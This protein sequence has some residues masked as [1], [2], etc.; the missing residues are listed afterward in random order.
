MRKSINFENGQRR[1]DVGARRGCA[2]AI[3]L[4]G[5]C[6]PAIA[7]AELP[8]VRERHGTP[9]SLASAWSY[10]GTS[11]LNT[12]STSAWSVRPTE[13][14]ALAR[15]LGANRLS[16]AAYA[17]AVQKYIQSNIAVEFRFGLGKG[18][19]GA[20]VDQSGTPFDQAQLMVEL[21]RE[22]GVVASYN[23]GSATLTAAQFG[24][25]TG[26][27]VPTSVSSTNQITAFTVLAK[28]A[29]ELAADG[30]IPSDL[31]TGAGCSTVT[32]NLS[33]ITIGH[34]WVTANGQSYDPS[35]K[36]HDLWQMDSGFVSAACG[37]SL[38]CS[39]SAISAVQTGA[40][41]TSTYVQSPNV[42]SLATAMRTQAI[43]AEARAKSQS[44]GAQLHLTREQVLG[45][46]RISQVQA[47]G[48]SLPYSTTT[49]YVF[50]GNVPDQFRTSAMITVPGSF[51]KL[52]YLDETAGRRLA[53]FDGMSLILENQTLATGSTA[54]LPAGTNVGITLNHPYA[55]AELSSGLGAGTYQDESESLATRFGQS[56]TNPG[57]YQI[58]LQAGEAS[59]SSVA[60]MTDLIKSPPRIGSISATSGMT[61][62]IAQCN[63]PSFDPLSKIAADWTSQY[64]QTLHLVEGVN[65]VRI[66]NHHAI[67]FVAN[68]GRKD[69]SG[70]ELTRTISGNFVGALSI[71]SASFDKTAEQGAAGAAAALF[72][73]IEGSSIEQNV[74][75]WSSGTASD[76]FRLKAQ[77]NTRFY[78]AAT[79]TQWNSIQGSLVGYSAAL[80]NLAAQFVAD[81]YTI[82]IPREATLLGTLYGL[83]VNDPRS[84]FVAWKPSMTRFSA[85][86]YYLGKGAG[87][88]EN[89][90]PVK[91]VKESIKA[92]TSKRVTQFTPDI[93]T[94]TGR[95]NISFPPDLAAGYG[96][97]PYGLTLNRTYSNDA[98]GPKPCVNT[99]GGIVTTSS[100]F[101]EP[102]YNDFLN[103]PGWKTSWDWDAQI[104]SDAD[105]ALGSTSGTDAAA[106]AAGV[107]TLS[108]LARLAT[109][110]IS[111]QIAL[112]VGG[113]LIADQLELNAVRVSR[114]ASSM[115]F[116][117]AADGTS[118]LPE[119]W[120]S[121]KLVKTGPDPVKTGFLFSFIYDFANIQFQLTDADGGVSSY[122]QYGGHYETFGDGN[123]GQSYL[124]IGP[125]V[126]SNRFKAVQW[127][128]TGSPRIQLDRTADVPP[129][130]VLTG[131]TTWLAGGAIT[132]VTNSLGRFIG[133]P[134]GGLT[135]SMQAEAN[136]NG[137]G[138]F[139]QTDDGRWIKYV[140]VTLAVSAPMGGCGAAVFHLGSCQLITDSL[141]SATRQGDG[142]T[143]FT[144]KLYQPDL[145]QMF[146]LET[147]KTQSNT[148]ANPDLRISYSAINRAEWSEDA[149]VQRTS[150][151]P[152]AL[153]GE[154]TKMGEV[155][156]PLGNLTRFTANEFGKTTSTTDPLLRITS[157]DYDRGGNLIAA[158]DA[159][160]GRVAYKYDLRGNRIEERKIAKPGSGLADLVKQTV[161]M[162]APTVTSCVSQITCNKV[163][164][165]IDPKGNRT[166]YAW[167]SATG[168][169]LSITSGFNA[170]GTCALAS[171]VCP[172]TTFTYSDVTGVD[173]V[174][175]KLLTSTTEKIDVTQTV[176]TSYEY[177]AAN[178]F[179]LKS[180]IVDPTGL[181]LR[182]CYKFDAAGNL[183]SQTEP[184][185][186]L[187]VCP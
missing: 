35:Y 31:G 48:G 26:L 175:F 161:Y 22:G 106:R 131:D 16:A 56:G 150:R 8:A 101:V 69:A 53:S 50:S 76:L 10:Y 177:D 23:V 120:H 92:P 27:V 21:L 110:T 59:P 72:V 123:D 79:T 90:D 169:I 135:P 154:V 98:T 124:L 103:E 126:Y 39:T 93:N 43:A 95:V 4:A 24:S 134:V 55:N 167:D 165:E 158:T 130:N 96:D 33:T 143:D 170:S 136:A 66:Q 30:G 142:K 112:V 34:V 144:Y 137:P 36:A 168:L 57:W 18:A 67:G 47:S 152:A 183:M 75:S 139:V 125:A 73:S 111:S 71:N 166:N 132:K 86:D 121:E 52:V 41:V 122:N 54:T 157:S 138:S 83:Q 1:R 117:K 180:S 64:A 38:D 70:A 88:D 63:A 133:Y 32:G 82:I 114:D 42:N 51:T 6:L 159:E 74:V 19:L 145:S 81:G 77:D 97:F 127:V 28:T 14:K 187:G 181:A 162:E 184:K 7:R 99:N 140:S 60:F 25:W 58:I 113:E 85:I 45:G 84:G 107:L 118:Y 185:A 49:Q 182:T 146:A 29:C 115:T 164:Y 148:T 153:Y 46:R 5:L 178:K 100:T 78:I 89:H 9:I 12:Q 119:A 105:R 176:T 128:R 40:T 160:G 3:L 151:Y 102:N 156:D 141:G 62:G 94:T 37:A 179:V 15:S 129:A 80:K 65:S 173:G 68:T 108:H 2:G 109:P 91:P 174:V 155:I 13:I 149:K 116:L 172:T 104:I 20:L 163:S 17:D 44:S 186:G 171:G 147:I 87:S 11:T 61:P